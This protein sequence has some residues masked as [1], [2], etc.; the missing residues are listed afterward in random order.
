MRESPALVTIV[1]LLV[2]LRSGCRS[3]I[4]LAVQ[5]GKLDIDQEYSMVALSNQGMKLRNWLCKI[6][7]LRRRAA[8]SIDATRSRPKILEATFQALQDRSDLVL[9]FFSYTRAI[10]LF[11][12]ESKN[13]ARSY[14]CTS[15]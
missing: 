4:L 10:Q 6:V 1:K 9:S 14:E 7:E 12:D 15:S 8:D 5:G 11:Y 3:T 13:A 2:W